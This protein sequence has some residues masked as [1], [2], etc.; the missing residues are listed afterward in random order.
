MIYLNEAGGEGPRPLGVH[1]VPQYHSLKSLMRADM[2][3]KSRPALP[4][5]TP[6]KGASHFP[7]LAT[8][9]THRD[10]DGTPAETEV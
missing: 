10:P 6:K 8:N 5:L 3:M 9:V 1:T 7:R 4:Q 2:Q